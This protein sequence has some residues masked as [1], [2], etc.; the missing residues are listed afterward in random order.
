MK[1]SDWVAFFVGLL[2]LTTLFLLPS[3][4]SAQ[5][6]WINEFHYDNVGADVGEFVEVVV[7]IGTNLNDI[8]VQTYNGD[9]GNQHKQVLIV[10]LSVSDETEAS[11]YYKKNTP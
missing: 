5:R 1:R 3:Q 7:E 2:L 8:F 4:L 11:K 6:M 10:G 9:N